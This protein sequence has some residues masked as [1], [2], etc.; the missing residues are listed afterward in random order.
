MLTGGKMMY[1]SSL[2]M[3]LQILGIPIKISTGADKLI[4]RDGCIFVT[5]SYIKMI[6]C[7][8]LATYV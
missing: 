2:P 3:N 8:L 4:R 5:I 1:V 7:P 6:H